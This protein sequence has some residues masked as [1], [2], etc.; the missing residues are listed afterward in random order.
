MMIA[1]KQWKIN[2][3]AVSTTILKCVK[4]GWLVDVVKVL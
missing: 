2:F 3:Q 1:H 4:A